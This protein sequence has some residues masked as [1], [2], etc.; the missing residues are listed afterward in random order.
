MSSDDQEHGIS[1]TLHLPVTGGRSPCNSFKAFSQPSGVVCFRGLGSGGLFFAMTLLPAVT[2]L[3]GGVWGRPIREWAV[4]GQ[5]FS[6]TL[7]VRF[8]SGQSTRIWLQAPFLGK[9]CDIFVTLTFFLAF[10]VY[11]NYTS[12]P[13]NYK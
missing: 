7:I 11:I 3:S 4:R 12:N 8:Y 10:I 9:I 5:D 2:S 1:S 6:P 13:N